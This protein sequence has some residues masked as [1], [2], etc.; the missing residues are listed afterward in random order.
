MIEIVSA[1]HAYLITKTSDTVGEVEAAIRSPHADI[2]VAYEVLNNKPYY[3]SVAIDAGLLVKSMTR[4]QLKGLINAETLDEYDVVM[5]SK[6]VY[7]ESD[8]VFSMLF[9]RS[10][11]VASRFISQCSYGI[12]RMDTDLLVHYVATA[13]EA[14]LSEQEQTVQIDEFRTAH[15]S[16]FVHA[17]KLL[18]VRSDSLSASSFKRLAFLTDIEKLANVASLARIP[19]TELAVAVFAITHDTVNSQEFLYGILQH[20]RTSD[21]ASILAFLAKTGQIDSVVLAFTTLSS[22]LDSASMSFSQFAREAVQLLERSEDTES[23]KRLA[24]LIL[25]MLPSTKESMFLITRILSA[26]DFNLVEDS[27]AIIT[28]VPLEGEFAHTFWG[29]YFQNVVSIRAQLSNTQSGSTFKISD[30]LYQKM[31]STKH[32]LFGIE[33]LLSIPVLPSERVVLENFELFVSFA[34]DFS[35]GFG[36]FVVSSLISDPVSTYSTELRLRVLHSVLLKSSSIREL[37]KSHV[38][39][40][41]WQMLVSLLA[42]RIGIPDELPDEFKERA[43]TLESDFYG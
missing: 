16:V 43:L 29:K 20:E 14:L 38:L 9:N 6:Q 36:S 17:V 26:V 31:I 28:A 3:T 25:K 24:F 5:L 35:E 42:E 33:Q 37:V 10:A 32:S 22:N 23:S 39:R 13:G 30:D 18:A 15:I 4:E 41:I 8:H 11:R 34:E 1:D 7:G 2:R 27:E 19:T 12:F 21:S 40:G